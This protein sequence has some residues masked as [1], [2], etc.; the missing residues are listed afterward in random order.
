[1]T[2]AQ[3]QYLLNRFLNYFYHFLYFF[4]G[5]VSVFNGSKSERIEGEKKEENRENKKTPLI[6]LGASFEASS[7]ED[8]SEFLIKPDNATPSNWKLVL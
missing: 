6:P 5:I 7:Q 1:M 8:T 3:P 2:Q 4:T